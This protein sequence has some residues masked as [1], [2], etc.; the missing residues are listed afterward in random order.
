MTA[1]Y[2]KP[3]VRPGFRRRNRFAASPHGA[4]RKRDQRIQQ[5]RIG[6]AAFLPHQ[7]VHAV[8]RKARHR[9]HLVDEQLAILLAQEEIDA[10]TGLSR[11][12]PG[13]RESPSRGPLPIFP[14]EYSPGY[15][16][17]ICHRYIWPYNRKTRW[18]TVISPA[19][20]S[21]RLVVAKHADLDL[22][23]ID[24]L[25]DDD[26]AVIAK[27]IIRRRDQ[28]FAV[29]RLGYADAGARLAGLT[30]HG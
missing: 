30:K 12:S 27:R 17:S 1:S 8:R 4:N 22:A 16:S 13:M 25:L 26:F 21:T 9:I 5:L 14:P 20:G 15:A 3:V 2:E 19:H 11:Q 18:K 6:Y 24:E 7:R 10:R 23:G 28:L 29:A